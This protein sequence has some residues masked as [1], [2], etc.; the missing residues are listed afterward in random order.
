MIEQ[1]VRDYIEAERDQIRVPPM[2]TQRI[3]RAVEVGRPTRKP[4]SF[5]SLR[6]A[7]AMASMLLLGLAIASIHITQSPAG[8]V[9]GA[10][11]AAPSMAE[12]RGSQ[13]A[14]LLPNGKV[15]VVGGNVASSP[16]LAPATAELYDPKTRT[17][18]SAGSLSTPRWGHT[19]TLLPNGK[20]LVAGGS[21]DDPYTPGSLAS[22]EI[23]DPGT[24]TWSAAASMHTPRSFHSATLLAD[25][26]VLIAGGDAVFN[27]IAGPSSHAISPS[28]STLASTELY[29]PAANRWTDG[30]AMI[31]PRA[32]HAATM[33]ADDRVLIVGGTAGLGLAEAGSGWRTAEIYDP[34]T[35][36]WSAAASMQ[37]ARVF[38]SA[39]LL[40]DGRVLVVGDDG[41]NYRTTELFDPSTGRWSS[42]PDSA[43]G[44]AEAATARLRDG[45]VLVAGG[46]GEK[47]A[48]I[49]DWHRNEWT[50]AGNLATLR[51]GATATLL[52]N[53]Q[54][55]VAGGF[56]N[57][58]MPWA[59]VELY[60]P[61]GSHATAVSRGASSP[62]S[63]I[64]D[65]A[66]VVGILVLLLGL[67]LWWI[68]ERLGTGR[69]R[70]D[71]WIDSST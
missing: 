2:L 65:I 69:A 7:A 58:A 12:G 3:L 59:S 53:G 13:T 67:G 50:N 17:W 4:R 39:N 31:T 46:L 27:D 37:F 68:V 34:A 62:S 11:T 41:V 29:D 51:S 36:A 21:P 40:P 6:V 1:R 33:L 43:V 26:R 15:L 24:N 23:Y 47:S 5:G 18:S 10:W 25:G 44:R 55:L 30:P 45:R 60:E 16:P 52:V 42:G 22:V 70:G 19:A 66:L 57:L 20:V 38:P 61:G 35:Q 63:P 32:K 9:Q 48:Q 28:V 14:T 56:G 8:L 71:L 54:V 49:F 64:G